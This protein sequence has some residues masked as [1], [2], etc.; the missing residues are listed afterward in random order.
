MGSVALSE[1]VVELVGAELQAWS[2]GVTGNRP[3][4][5]PVSP[6]APVM[7]QVGHIQMNID[8]LQF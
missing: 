2:I 6:V 3:S 5:Q 8:M 7:C 4:G 1:R